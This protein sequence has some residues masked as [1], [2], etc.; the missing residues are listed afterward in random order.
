MTLRDGGASLPR[1]TPF[2]RTNDLQDGSAARSAAAVALG[3]YI[4]CTPLY[5]L[6]RPLA[7]ALGGAL[8]LDRF[9]TQIASNLAITGA[10]PFVFLLEMQVGGWLLHGAGHTVRSFLE[11]GAWDLICDLLLGGVFVG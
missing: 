9:T 1:S 2:A 10:A 3:T 5:G 6:H 4:G 8:A 11:A 7:R